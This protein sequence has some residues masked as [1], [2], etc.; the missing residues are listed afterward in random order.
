MR[1]GRLPA[2]K[3]GTKTVLFYHDLDCYMASLPRAKFKTLKEEAEA[4][5]E[6]PK[7]KA[8]AEERREAETVEGTEAEAESDSSVVA[9]AEELSAT[10]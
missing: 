9:A 1:D 10:A 2:Y 3:N 4:E 5:A 7:R 8:V 6:D